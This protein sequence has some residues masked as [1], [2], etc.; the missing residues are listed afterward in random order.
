MTVDQVR[1]FHNAVPFQPFVITLTDGRSIGVEEPDRIAMTPSGRT[2]A[3]VVGKKALELF[4]LSRVTGLKLRERRAAKRKSRSIAQPRS[5]TTTSATIQRSAKQSPT[6]S[7]R[8][9]T[10]A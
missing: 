7:R 1:E 10:L 9:Q 5:S 3:V 6:K 8:V 2:I 4:D